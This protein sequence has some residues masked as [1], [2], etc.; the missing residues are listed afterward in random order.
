MNDLQTDNNFNLDEAT[1]NVLFLKKNIGKGIIAL[2]K[3]LV[4]VKENLPYGEWM[5]WLKRD[6]KMPYVSAYRYMKV[7]REIDYPTLEKVGPGKV[8]EILELPPSSFRD[9]LLNLAPNLTTSEVREEVK[10]HKSEDEE[11]EKDQ[12]GEEEIIEKTV[13]S[14]QYADTAMELNATLLDA[15]GRV[16][17]DS[18]EEYYYDLLESQFKKTVKQVAD[19]LEKVK[20]A[21]SQK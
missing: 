9:E 1:K 14:K 13:G 5:E 16:E 19:F 18:L 8:Y 6:I 3:W 2:G 12:N 7:A 20:Y 10:K 11:L 4:L 21:Q 17:L 15:I